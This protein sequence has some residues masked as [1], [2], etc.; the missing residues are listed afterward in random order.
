MVLNEKRLVVLASG[1]GSNLQVIIDGIQRGEI[2]GRI[3]GV[4]SNR[5]NAFALERAGKH[6]IRPI[7]I[8]KG[9]YP[10]KQDRDLAL[11]TELE[12]LNPDLIVLAGY[13]EI[14][15]E[16]IIKKYENKIMNIHP[17]L[18]P[19]FCGNGYYGMHVHKAVVEYG[20]KVTGATVHFVDTGTDTGPVVM[21]EVVAVESDDTPE[22]VQQ[23]VLKIE[24]QLLPQAVGLF[25]ED[26][27]SVVGRKVVIGGENHG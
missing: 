15:P 11:L 10:Q 22:Q 16:E 13:L 4:V 2:R 19:S 27:I 1:G 24:H 8:G 12:N 9:K 26:K 5:K 14:I 6:D 17:A 18:I 25:C 21:Q 20:V 7:Y 3:V 23:N